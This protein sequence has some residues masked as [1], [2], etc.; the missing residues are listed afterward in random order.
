MRGEFSMQ[1]SLN[2]YLIIVRRWAWVIVLGVVVCGSITYIMSRLTKPVYQATVMFVVSTDTSNA[3]SSIA[4]VPTYAQLLTNPL[5]LNPGVSNHKGMTLSQLNGMITV[6]PQTN[7]QLIELDV[8]GND[9][10]F[11][12]QVANEV[13]QSYLQYA[14]SQLPNSLE[15]LP[16]VVPSDPIKP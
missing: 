9:P 7:T 16:A 13:G 8:Q 11:A 15:M 2:R 1:G 5:A 4:S 3:L 6:K 12:A 10:R 14:N